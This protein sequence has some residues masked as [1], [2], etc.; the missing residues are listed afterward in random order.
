MDDRRFLTGRTD[1]RG[2]A[3]SS[4]AASVPWW[5]FTKTALATAALQLVARGQ[6]MLD[7]PVDGRRYTLRQLLQHRAGVPDYGHLT[8][9]HEA[10][11]RGDPLWDAS[12]LFARVAVDHL[13][14]EPGQGWQYSNLGYFLVRRMIET[15]TGED[16]GSALRHLIFDSLGL[17]SVRLATCVNDLD[18]TEWGNADRYDPG[19]VFHGLLVGTPGDAVR[20]LH[21]L[22]LGEVLPRA[23]LSSM[24]DRFAISGPVAGRPWQTAGYGL[25]LM[26]GEMAGAGLGVG[27]SGAGPGSIAAVYHFGNRAQPCTVAAFA[28]GHAQGHDEAVAEFEV[29][30]LTGPA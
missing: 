28:P 27:H 24:T 14:F 3:A 1:G 8:I 4:D 6:L 12:Q 23:L 16:L 29:A 5:S 18:A 9:Y 19:W 20:F 21:R 10:V 17:A 22:M 26:I 7:D 11:R 13:D 15:A 30:R 25:G 2:S